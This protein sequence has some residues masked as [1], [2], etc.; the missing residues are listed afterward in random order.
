M[1]F[2][3]RD[4]ILPCSTD[5]VMCHNRNLMATRNFAKKKIKKVKKIQKN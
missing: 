1:T 2:N 4:I 3:T 5:I